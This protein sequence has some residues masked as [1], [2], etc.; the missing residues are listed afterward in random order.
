MVETAAALVELLGVV[1]I[2]IPI[3]LPDRGARSCDLEARQRLGTGQ[4]SRVFPAPCR[5][6]LA[7]GTYAECCELSFAATGKKIS[8][9]AHAILPKIRDLDQVITPELQR[10]IR[11]VHPEVSFRELN[12]RPLLHPKKTSGGRQERMAILGAQGLACDWRGERVRLGRHRV[13]LDD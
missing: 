6:C 3:G 13:S 5:A 7:A 1:A 4:G 8:K 10:R 11:E 9:Q 12:G 2:D